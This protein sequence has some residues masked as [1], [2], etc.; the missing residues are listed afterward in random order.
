[1]K[2]DSFLILTFTVMIAYDFFARTFGFVIP[3][4]KY[5]LILFF[6]FYFKL[7][8]KTHFNK[9]ALYNLLALNVYVLINFIISNY[10]NGFSFLVTYF[11]T[12]LFVIVFVISSNIRIRFE[13]IQ[14]ILHSFVLILLVCTLPGVIESI[15]NFETLRY[16]FG[17]FRGPGTMGSLLVLGLIFISYLLFINFTKKLKYL[18]YL[19]ALL[20]FL[21]AIKKAIISVLILC[22]IIFC[23][24]KMLFR[25][26][27]SPLLIMASVPI[28]FLGS[29][30]VINGIAANLIYFNNVDPEDHVRL[31]MYI[32]AYNINTNSFPFGTGF[33][34]FGTL[35][36][37][38][39][40]SF[41]STGDYKLNA[42]YGEYN[43]SNL[44][45]LGEDQIN[46]V[47]GKNVYLD[48]WIPGL[49]TELG[50]L[51]LFFYLTLL[52]S[53]SSLFTNVSDSFLFV[54]VVVIRHWEGLL[55]PTPVQPE[56]IFIPWVILGLLLSRS[57]HE[58]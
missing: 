31:A 7:T 55:G 9:Y 12:F 6:I 22:F 49:I 19:F 20:I 1:M 16:N 43:L 26:L 8:H 17:F 53:L 27:F 36:S 14:K 39:D 3:G 58:S 32:N 4:I 37:M 25:K 29:F 45:G 21:T 56:F 10:T 40:S 41:I 47:D 34:T 33:G 23:F 38:I 54:S 11:Q 50:V 13:R 18:F 42:I 44:G 46:D 48:T 51:G 2:S 24:N 5:L 28:I 52:K 57:K 15:L 30:E 35:G